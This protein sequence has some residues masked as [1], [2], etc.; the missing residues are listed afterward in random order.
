MMPQPPVISHHG[1]HEQKAPQ[2][3]PD[4]ARVGPVRRQAGSNTDAEACGKVIRTGGPNR[5][6]AESSGEVPRCGLP[7]ESGS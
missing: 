4:D 2:A 7:S 3:A 6:G 1:Q 5:E